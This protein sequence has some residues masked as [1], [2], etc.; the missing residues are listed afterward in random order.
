MIRNK[1]LVRDTNCK[2]RNFMEKELLDR[3]TKLS[4]R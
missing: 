1:L 3:E 2:I 4:A